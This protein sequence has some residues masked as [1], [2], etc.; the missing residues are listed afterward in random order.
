MMDKNTTTMMIEEDGGLEERPQGALRVTSVET[1]ANPIVERKKSGLAS[2][3]RPNIRERWGDQASS[4]VSASVSL[5]AEGRKRS[6][7]P[8]EEEEARKRRLKGGS[9]LSDSDA[10]TVVLAEE[11]E[12]CIASALTVAGAFKKGRGRPLSTGQYIGLAKAKRR[13]SSSCWLSVNYWR[14]R[15][16]RAR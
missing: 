10:D 9:N 7:L 2:K 11:E 15:E 16:S 1:L 6:A 13:G 3:T 12:Q 5:E 14:K 8:E 4:S